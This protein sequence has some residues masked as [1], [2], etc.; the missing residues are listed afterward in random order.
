MTAIKIMMVIKKKW[1]LAIKIV[2]VIKK[3]WKL[4][5]KI[6]TVI[7][8]LKKIHAMLYLFVGCVWVLCNVI[9]NI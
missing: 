7:K 9:C 2:M 4:P 1:E 8:N 3:K 5:L 6:V